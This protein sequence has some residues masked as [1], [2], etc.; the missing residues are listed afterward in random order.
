[1]I[2]T[3]L[4][5]LLLLLLLEPTWLDKPSLLCD[6]ARI[7]L[8]YGTPTTCISHQFD[9]SC[10]GGGDGGCRGV[11]HAIKPESGKINCQLRFCTF[12]ICFCFVTRKKAHQRTVLHTVL[13][14]C[15]RA[16]RTSPVVQIA[17]VS[18]IMSGYPYT[19]RPF[20]LLCK[21]VKVSESNGGNHFYRSARAQ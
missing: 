17:P 9:S 8:K 18:F 12:F 19:S 7:V 2:R 16:T 14:Y 4:L 20:L 11:M 3:L 21:I 5:L 1:M 6:C 15:N 10:G 13:Q